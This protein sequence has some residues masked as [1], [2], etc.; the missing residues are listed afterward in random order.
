MSKINKINQTNTISIQQLI[1]MMLSKWYLITLATLLGAFIAFGY[2]YKFIPKLYTA[3]IRL[4]VNNTSI[5]IGNIS[6]NIN[7]G[8]LAAAQSLVETY[9]V[10]LKSRMTLE[11]IIDEADLPYTT[12]Q[13]NSMLSTGAVNGTEIFYVNVSS[14]NPEE[15]CHIANTIAR[16]LPSQ[17][18]EIVE[19]SSMKIVDTA[20]VPSS[21][22]SPNYKKNTLLGAA[23]GMMLVCALIFMLNFF[24]DTVQSESSLLE[25]LDGEIPIIGS[26]PD[27][28]DSSTKHGYYNYG[29][30]KESKS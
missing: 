27:I 21:F 25:A 6:A 5:S 8:E 2:T 4:Y 11:K 9:C 3:D 14:K 15:A 16:V 20:V 24:N 28:Y 26:V 22:S 18:K 7:S 23:I 1:E 17:V 30:K 12:S 29:K 19:G 10:I 13:L